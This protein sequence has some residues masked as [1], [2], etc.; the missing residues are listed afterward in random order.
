[1]TIVRISQTLK[2]AIYSTWKIKLIEGLIMHDSSFLYLLIMLAS[3]EYINAL[4][5]NNSLKLKTKK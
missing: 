3:I 5:I 2:L 1:M 4:E